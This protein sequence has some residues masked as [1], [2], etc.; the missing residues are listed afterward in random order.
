MGGLLGRLEH[1]SEGGVVL[2]ARDAAEG[3][4]PAEDVASRVAI[5]GARGQELEPR[6][7][8]GRLG[9]EIAVVSGDRRVGDRRGGASGDEAG[10]LVD[11]RTGTSVVGGAPGAHVPKQELAV[12]HRGHEDPAQLGVPREAALAQRPADPFY[13]RR[14]LRERGQL[15][16]RRAAA[17]G[18][19]GALQGFR[20]QLA[21]AASQELGVELL[22]VVAGF[23][24]EEVEESDGSRD[25]HV[26]FRRVSGAGRY[27]LRRS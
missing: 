22:D 6:A 2:H 26:G 27:M 25:R 24:N 1:V 16:H 13:S 15:G 11:P 18:A 20:I 17:Q 19:C 3:P 9:G 8:V 7:D 23:E 12:V 10:E 5:V 21:G 4:D 14:H